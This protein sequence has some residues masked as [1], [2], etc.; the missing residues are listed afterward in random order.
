LSVIH[1]GELRFRTVSQAQDFGLKLLYQVMD[2]RYSVYW[3]GVSM[4]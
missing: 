3:Q 1:D 2:E 4:A